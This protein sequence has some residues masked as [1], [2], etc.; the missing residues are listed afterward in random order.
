MAKYD[1][2]KIVREDGR[3]SLEEYAVDTEST[4]GLAPRR[5]RINQDAQNTFGNGP[6]DPA[7]RS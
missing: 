3:S 5:E 7:P 2:G 4:Q 1:K 6:D